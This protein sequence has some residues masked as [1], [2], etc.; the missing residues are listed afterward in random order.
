MAVHAHG[1]TTIVFLYRDRSSTYGRAGHHLSISSTG[2][3]NATVELC[4]RQQ[5]KQAGKCTS[6]DPKWHSQFQLEDSEKINSWTR[7]TPS[8][9]TGSD[10][11][12]RHWL[13]VLQGVA[14][15]YHL[16]SAKKR[17]NFQDVSRRPG[18]Q[19]HGSRSLPW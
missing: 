12:R 4:A 8:W 3:S 16:S 9:K 13:V 6:S 11:P 14:R 18:L 17:G 15:S 5:Q 10:L 7:K 1:S 2:K 19:R